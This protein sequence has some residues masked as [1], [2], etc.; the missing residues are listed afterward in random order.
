MLDEQGAYDAVYDPYVLQFY[1]TRHVAQA[2]EAD[3]TD[4]GEEMQVAVLFV[5]AKTCTMIREV[6]VFTQKPDFRYIFGFPATESR[7][8][9]SHLHFYTS[10]FRD[11]SSQSFRPGW[12]ATKRTSPRNSRSHTWL[13][14]FLSWLDSSPFPTL[15]FAWPFLSRSVEE[16]SH[17]LI[18]SVLYELQAKPTKMEEGYWNVLNSGS[19]SNYALSGRWQWAFHDPVV[20]TGFD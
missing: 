19:T 2:D 5:P 13:D 8:D 10:T 1:M 20:G 9:T 4:D 18:V 15:T 17:N 11:H 3:M 12:D 16:D 6:Q 14:M 7:Y